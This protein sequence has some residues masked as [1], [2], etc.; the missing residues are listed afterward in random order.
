MGCD[1]D[2]GFVSASCSR[3]FA[4]SAKA[5]GCRFCSGSSMAMSGGGLGSIEQNKIFNETA[6]VPPDA[7]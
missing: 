4:M 3:K 6:H 7:V 5:P 1:N 2:L